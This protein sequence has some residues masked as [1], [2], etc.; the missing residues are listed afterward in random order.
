VLP[1]L[2]V[3]AVLGIEVWL[4]LTGRPTSPLGRI[5]M[6]VLVALLM[7]RQYLTLRQ[8]VR[9]AAR[10]SAREQE[11]RHQA[12]HDRLTGLANRALFSDRLEHAVHLHAR[13]G[14]PVAV[15]F[16]D[17]DDFKSVNDSLG[18]AAGDQLLVRVAERVQGAV[19]TGDTVARLG[20]DEFG[21]LLESGDDPGQAAARIAA[22]LRAPFPVGG[23]SVQVRAST[24]IARLTGTDVPIDADEL[25]IRADGA[26]YTAKR[27]TKAAAGN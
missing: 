18:H 26:M 13:D 17:L 7:A 22:A 11:L 3:M 23:G 12:F 24:G 2:P 16:L 8:N 1:Y 10:V 4:G 25:L 21:V 19:R 6:L 9:L 14:R 27:A 15:L 5:G 20:G